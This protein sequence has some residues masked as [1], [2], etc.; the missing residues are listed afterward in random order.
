A[1]PVFELRPVVFPDVELHQVNRLYLQVFQAAVR[2]F[3]NVIVREDVF[4]LVAAPRRPLAVFGR[5]LRGG[6]EA[7]GRRLLDQLAE[8]PLAVPRAVGPGRV[9]EVAAELDGP[10]Q[11]LARLFVVRAFPLAHAPHAITDFAHLPAGSPESTVLH[12]ATSSWRSNHLKCWRMYPTQS[13]SSTPPK[14]IARCS[15]PRIR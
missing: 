12:E 7:L 8:Q 2:V 10:A 1:L 5:D 3:N 4:K 9:E 15:V 6:V 11:R 13:V 14:K